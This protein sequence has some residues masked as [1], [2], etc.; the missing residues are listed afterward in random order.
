M[1]KKKQKNETEAIGS[2]E[3]VDKHTFMS[4]ILSLDVCMWVYNFQPLECL[5]GGGWGSWGLF[6]MG[7]C[8]LPL[9]N[10]CL[11][12]AQWAAGIF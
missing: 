2:S 10:I 1:K 8:F 5:S 6:M 11:I 7:V 9:L 4:L 12:E 3:A